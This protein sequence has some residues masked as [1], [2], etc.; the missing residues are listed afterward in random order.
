MDDKLTTKT[1]KFISLENLY[2]WHT[3]LAPSDCSIRVIHIAL[4]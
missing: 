2:V 3:T 1:A 4:W